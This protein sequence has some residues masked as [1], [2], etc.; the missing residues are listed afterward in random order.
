MLKKF[1]IGISVTLFVLINLFFL[2]FAGGTPVRFSFGNQ[3][4]T[5]SSTACVEC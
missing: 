5:R 4:T 3:D 2:D 1:R